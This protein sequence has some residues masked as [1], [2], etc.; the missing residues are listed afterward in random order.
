MGAEAPATPLH[1]P[2]HFV[3]DGLSGEF[4]PTSCRQF[5]NNMETNGK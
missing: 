3:F 2:D 5:P 4:P 1:L